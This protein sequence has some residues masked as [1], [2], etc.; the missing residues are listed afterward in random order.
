MDEKTTSQ[1]WEIRVME[2]MAALD[3]LPL[4][5]LSQD[6]AIRLIGELA[7]MKAAI[8]NEREVFPQEIEMLRMRI[9]RMAVM[10]D[11]LQLRYGDAANE[12]QQFLE[13]I[14]ESLKEE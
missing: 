13:A 12:E 6:I 10:L 9:G 1:Q 8:R 5:D 11:V 7:D 14:E 2:E 3:E 4:L